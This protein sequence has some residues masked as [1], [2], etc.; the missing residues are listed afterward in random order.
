MK[1]ILVD[2]GP[3]IALFRKRDAYHQQ[4]LTFIKSIEGRLITTW[5]VITE[6]MY[7][8]NHPEIQE[9]FLLWIERGG[10]EI[11]QQD[12]HAIPGLLTLIKKYSD[13]PMDLAD[14]T[15]ML[16][17][18]KTGINKIATIRKETD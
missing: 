6:V 18:E 15:L 11:A 14:A 3:L 17:A 8:L 10:L 2:A 4:A 12:G 13:L 1:S 7:V 16:Y 9:K 5:P